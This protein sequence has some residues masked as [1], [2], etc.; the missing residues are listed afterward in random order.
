[1]H[2]LITAAILAI[3]TIKFVDFELSSNS[4]LSD[5][6]KKKIRSFVGTFAGIV[7]VNILLPIIFLESFYVNIGSRN[8]YRNTVIAGLVFAV[9][10]FC[11]GYALS[12]IVFTKIHNRW[13]DIAT[14]TFG[15]GNRGI[16]LLTTI[17]IILE[18]FNL[19][20]HSRHEYLTYFYAFDLGNFISFFI[21]T[22]VS[23]LVDC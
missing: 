12:K 5:N 2:K 19:T 21:M 18:K 15:G 17:V 11:I 6:D 14:A 7:S 8:M 20:T 10:T 22:Q 3:L 4:E 13:A 16:L 23:E 1:M 9:I